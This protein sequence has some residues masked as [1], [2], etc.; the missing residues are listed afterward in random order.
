[1]GKSQQ[2][3]ATTSTKG[4][5]SGQI[6]NFTRTFVAE[7][8][9]VSLVDLAKDAG[10]AKWKVSDDSAFLIGM[11]PDLRKLVEEQRLLER[12]PVLKVSIETSKSTFP[13]P[14]VVNFPDI[15]KKKYT[16]RNGVTADYF[17][18]D[19]ESAY[20]MKNVIYD[21]EEMKDS[22]IVKKFSK[23]IPSQIDQDILTPDG[24]SYSYVPISHPV[25]RF[26]EEH[27]EE[28]QLELKRD[29]ILDGK[30]HKI[31]S[32]LVNYVNLLLGPMIQQFFTSTNLKEFELSI[33][34]ADGRK[35][36]D[37]TNVLDNVKTEAVRAL[38]MN[39]KRS[40]TLVFEI[41]YS[42]IPK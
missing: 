9:G 2:R 37:A 28:I 6:K 5:E 25:V 22:A 17:V 13:V 40:L 4:K 36:D 3:K 14:L 31:P 15:Q 29:D 18:C 10:L 20:N 1:M 8:T 32:D 34:R 23:Y 21:A 35:F 41:T 12:A 11:E 24:E 38:T 27:P 19:M 42:L 16:F 26:V 39:M 33:A 7:W 30:Y